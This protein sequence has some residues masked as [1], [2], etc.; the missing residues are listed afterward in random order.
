QG[1]LE[2]AGVGDAFGAVAVGGGECAEVGVVQVRAA[3]A[4]GVL[5]L[6]VH[7][8]GAVTAV[9]EQQHDA[10]SAV[11]DRRGQLLSVHEEVAVAG[12]GERRA[13]GKDGGGHTSGHAVAHGA[14][15]GCELGLVAFDQTVITIEPVQPAG[16]V[17]GAVGEHGVGR[18]VLLQ[19]VD[20]GR[21]VDA[22]WQRD[23]TVGGVNVGQVI[24][25]AGAGPV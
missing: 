21:H 1:R 6:L 16:E 4:G 20:D 9:V 14:V 5:A 24:G 7:A 22:A 23:A 15:G 12:N 19:G 3:G 13:S 18:Q 17:A 25:V 11:H 8:D 10:F 2:L